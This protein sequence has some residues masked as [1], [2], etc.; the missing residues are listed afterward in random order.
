MV[1]CCGRGSSLQH[2]IQLEPLP[3]QYT[4]VNLP[5][6][7]YAAC[8]FQVRLQRKQMQYQIQVYLPSFMFVIVSW[9][10]FLVKPEVVPGRMAMLVTLFLVLINIFNSVREQAPISSR[11]NAVDLYLVVCVFFVFSAL[12][13]Y[14]AILMLLKKRRKP[15]RTI[16]E[17]LKTIFPIATRN[18]DVN[19]P[20]QRPER[21]KNN[22]GGGVA[23]AVPD[24]VTPHKQALCDNIDAWA[25]WISPPVFFFFNLVYWIAYR[26]VHDFDFDNT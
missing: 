25:L 7:H 1:Y 5:S 13:E 9:V 18:G 8:G 22:V 17:G 11:L 23:R 19:Q 15:K 2:F 16:D 6:G 4:I 3:Q 20:V 12:M 10:S 14:A 26:H 21:K 24:T